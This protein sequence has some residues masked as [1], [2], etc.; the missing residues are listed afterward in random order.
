MWHCLR[1]ASPAFRSIVRP[2]TPVGQR[3]APFSLPLPFLAS[4]AFPLLPSFSPGGK[5]FEMHKV[6]KKWYGQAR[7]VEEGRLP[8][9][10]RKREEEEG[11]GVRRS[12][13]K[14]PQHEW[15]RRA[16]STRLR[17]KL[18]QLSWL[19]NHLMV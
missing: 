7:K 5:L 12:P 10:Q 15:K 17:Q 6:G 8:C 16:D 19:S 2:P 11:R 3:K 9:H 1:L 18:L 13:F 14:A 4:C